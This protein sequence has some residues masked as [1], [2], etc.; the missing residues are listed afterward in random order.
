MNNIMCSEAC[1]VQTADQLVVTGGRD[2][3]DPDE[4]L[5]RVIVYSRTGEA[6]IDTLPDLNV[7]RSSHAC[8]KFIN[9]DGDTVRILHLDND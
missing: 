8:G 2:S 9:G 7:G 3:S 5:K 4:V 1:G 6:D